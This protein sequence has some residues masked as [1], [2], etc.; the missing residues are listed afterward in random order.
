MFEL[1]MAITVCWL[2]VNS[3]LVENERFALQPDPVR[4]PLRLERYR[5]LKELG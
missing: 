2:L 1:I 5:S 4:R 3:F